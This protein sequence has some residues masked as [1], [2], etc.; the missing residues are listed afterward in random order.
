MGGRA[1]WY[2]RFF[3]LG[4]SCANAHIIRRRHITP[5]AYI[6][7]PS[8]KPYVIPRPDAGRWTPG[9][10]FVFFYISLDLGHIGMLK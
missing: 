4:H 7:Y 1:G 10:A 5:L 9:G 8:A 3:V 2:V 6:I